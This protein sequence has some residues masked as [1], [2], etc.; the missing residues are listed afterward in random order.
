[1][2]AEDGQ[3]VIK[4]QKIAELELDLVGSQ[5]HASAYSSYLNAQKSLNS[6]FNNYRSSQASLAVVYDEIKGHDNDETLIMKE[7]RTKA[8]VANDNA[9]DG[10]ISAKAQLT[11]AFLSYNQSSQIIT[12]PAAGI[13]K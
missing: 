1:M 9:Y 11:S 7:K 5:R 4:G 6:A 3:R 12:A 10:T 8:E 13:V 2:F